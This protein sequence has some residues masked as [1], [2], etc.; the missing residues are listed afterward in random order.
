MKPNA[1]HVINSL[2]QQ[3]GPAAAGAS[4]RFSGFCGLCIAE[5]LW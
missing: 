4:N 2:L 5:E 3:G 1:A